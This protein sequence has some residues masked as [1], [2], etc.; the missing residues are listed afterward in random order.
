VEWVKVKGHA[1]NPANE[2][3][4]ALVQLAMDRGRRR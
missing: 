2:R 4:H 1:G 3:C